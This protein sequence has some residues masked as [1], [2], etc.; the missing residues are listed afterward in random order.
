MTDLSNEAKFQ[1][2]IIEQM[3][4]NGW[5]LGRPEGYSRELA[6][7][8]E[9]V[10]GFIQDTQ[11]EQ[12]QKFTT[13][14]PNNAEQKLLELV[15]GQLNKADPNATERESRKFGTLGVLRHELRDRNVR[16]SLCQFKPDHAL[17]PDTLA[18]YQQNRLRLVPELVYS[19]WATAAEL[20]E[21]GTRA[22]AW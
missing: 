17:N 7:Y 20:T 11:P 15:A 5:Q 9:D 4:N 19:P 12:W 6:L 8:S 13:L 10:I 1:R 14:Y 16:F 22:K 18:R 2:D 3:L 21:T